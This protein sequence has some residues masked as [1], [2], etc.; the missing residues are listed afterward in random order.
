MTVENESDLE[1]LKK[2][3][4]IVGLTLKEM[5]K[6]VQAGMSTAELDEVGRKTLKK[7][8]ARSAPFLTYGFPGSTCISINEEAAHGIPGERIIQRGDLVNIDVSAELNGYYAD[9][10]T[11]VA[12]L[13]ISAFARKL[14]NCTLQAR[15]KAIQVAKAGHSINR[16]GQVIE[17]QAKRCGLTVIR[18]L[19]GHGVGRAL[20]EEPTIP[21]Y[22]DPKLVDSFKNGQ[23]VT[24]EPFLADGAH[25]I[26]ETGDGFTLKTTNGRLS[27]QYEHTIIITKGKPL[28]ITAV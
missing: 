8:G 22:F 23:V 10:A 13:P 11:T 2:I 27:A 16:V 15:N 21:G 19:P 7:L 26:K 4:R 3:G 5:E 14:T 1:G 24:I 12:I 9:A 18:D 25:H 6:T 17:S 28:V 20:H